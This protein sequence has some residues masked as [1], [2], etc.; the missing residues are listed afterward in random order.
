MEWLTT[1]LAEFIT[2]SFDTLLVPLQNTPN[3]IFIVLGFVGLLFWLKTQSKLSK[4]AA[5]DP[6]QLK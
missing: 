5:N 1:P 3:N 6:N 2:W 4:K